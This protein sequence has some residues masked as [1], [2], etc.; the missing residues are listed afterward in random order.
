MKKNLEKYFLV[1]L[2]LFFII[3]LF[4]QIGLTQAEPKKKWI[5]LGHLNAFSGGLSLYGNDGK[6]SIILAMEE[7]NQK[8]GINVGGEQY[9]LKAIHIDNKYKPGPAVAGYRRLVDLHDVHF[10]H[11]MGTM[12]GAALIQYNEKDEVLLDIL[13]PSATTTVS[14]NKL[15]LNPVARSNGYEPPVVREAIK[16]GMKTMCI[17]ADDSES[18][19]D[20]VDR[21]VPVY[22]ELGGKILGVEYVKASTGVDFMTELT[23]IKGYKPDCLYI[24][25]ME[26]P[27]M[28]IGKQAREAGITAKLLFNVHFKQKII[29]V[30]G[31][32]N[33]EGTLFAGS[34]TT[35]ISTAPK[36]TPKRFLEYRDRYFKRWPG[37]YICAT[38][39]YIYNW[40][41]YISKAMQIAGTTTDVWK[42]RAACNQAIAQA[43]VVMDFKGCT[44]GGRMYG[45]D[46]Y[47]MGIENGKVCVIEKVSYSKELAAEG[48]K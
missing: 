9:F 22:T 46:I 34:P 10:I 41:Y 16:R 35:L 18:G 15:V 23:K 39:P 3:S 27:N 26:E 47:A 4:W 44:K 33:L 38:G 29:D 28:R 2:G 37:K 12:A 45:Q 48:E 25:A 11:N 13:T 7:I 17:I 20:Y 21:I 24:L 42:V 31:I 30:I 32:E 40:V 36:G 19:K 1:V 14:G 6:R 5:T 8:G 43:K